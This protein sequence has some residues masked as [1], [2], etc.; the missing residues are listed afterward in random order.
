MTQPL[1]YGSTVIG[2]I[3]TTWDKVKVDSSLVDS[4]GGFSCAKNRTVPHGVAHLRPFNVSTNGE[5]E[6]TPGTLHIP[7]NF[8]KD[9]A[10]FHLLPGDVLYNNT[11]SVELVGKTAIVRKPMAVAFSNHINRLRVRDLSKLDPRWLALLLRNLQSQ[12]FFATHSNKWIGQAGFSVTALA[13]V[14]IPLPVMTEQRRILTH[15]ES[16]QSNL[17]K[18]QKTL[19]ELQV[20]TR[21]LMETVLAEKY[22]ALCNEHEVVETGQICTSI[23]DGNHITPKYAETGVPFL[24][25][26]NIV[27]RYLDFN[28]TKFVT[29]DYYQGITDSRKPEL[30]DILYT[31]VGSYGVPVEVNDARPFCFQ[32]H[33][34]ILKPDRHKVFPSFL[35]W[36]LDAPQVKQQADAV[37]TGS[38][39]KTLTLT[40]LRKLTI[41]CPESQ[42][43]QREVAAYCDS[44]YREI[45]EMTKT[46]TADAVHFEEIE[47]SILIQAS[48]GEL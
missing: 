47:Q 25:V 34:G 45:T 8:R 6:I 13:E 19:R 18:C 16:L 22:R 38:A 35:R 36:M 26:S 5:V 29:E 17:R 7:E 1:Y 20:D 30:G 11:N 21:C 28:D 31:V 33:I 43:A 44:V 23:T 48:R 46:Q 32:R 14:E 9:V 24:F 3:P 41:P 42:H 15:I 10:T 37:V 4:L 40:Y 39:Q 27:N 2:E 12:G